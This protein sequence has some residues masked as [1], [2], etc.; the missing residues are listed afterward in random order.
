V[1]KDESYR[2]TR[3]ATWLRNFY[4]RLRGVKIGKN[5]R[6]GRGARFDRHPE[7]VTLEDNVII[8]EGNILCPTNKNARIVIGKNT[9]TNLSCMFYAVSSITVGENCLIAPRVYIVDNNH[10]IERDSLIREQRSVAKEIRIGN[11]CWLGANAMVLAGVTLAE[12]TI[13]GAMALVS[14]DTEPY[15][16]YHGIPAR[17]V[18]VR[19]NRDEAGAEAAA[20]T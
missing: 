8:G 19:P 15:G 17:L 6:I 12:G 2:N 18:R 3:K 11:D 5:V 7:N 20:A 4:W 13:V 10:G 16:I 14:K 9:G 1:A